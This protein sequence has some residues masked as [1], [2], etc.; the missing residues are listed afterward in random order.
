MISQQH[1]SLVVSLFGIYPSRSG[2]TLG[3]TGPGALA[4]LSWNSV[5]NQVELPLEKRFLLPESQIKKKNKRLRG[6][7]SFNN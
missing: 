3:K 6:V 2:M 1:P 5:D 7:Q 4:L